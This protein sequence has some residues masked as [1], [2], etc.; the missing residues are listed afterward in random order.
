M[1]AGKGAPVMPDLIRLYI[2]NVI[3]GFALSGIFVGLLFWFNVA[4][5]WHLVSTSDVGVMAAV[6]L[7]VLNGIVFAGVQFA[8]AIMSMAEKDDDDPKGGQLTAHRDM[9]P[10]PVSK[11]AQPKSST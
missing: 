2:R 10:V 3:I 7:F 11:P 5:L 8:Y 4:G 1:F 6:V 9:I